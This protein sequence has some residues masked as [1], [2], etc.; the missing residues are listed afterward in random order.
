[1]L[2]CS[3]AFL[4]GLWKIDNGIGQTAMIALSGFAIGLVVSNCAARDS[5]DLYRPVTPN[6]ISLA[7]TRV[8]PSLTSLAVSITLGE[9]SSNKQGHRLNRQITAFGLAGA[10]AGPT[11]FAVAVEDNGLKWLPLA[12]V[13]I[14]SMLIPRFSIFCQIVL[15]AITAAGFFT[16]PSNAENTKVRRPALIQL[17]SGS[18]LSITKTVEIRD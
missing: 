16:L 6:I 13:S 7:S 9:L 8:P 4:V 3:A 1:M 11:I 15:C 2:V 18:N 14:H 5:I 17:E 10:G 12:V